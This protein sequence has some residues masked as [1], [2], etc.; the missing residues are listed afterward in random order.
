M[1][2]THY[3][4]QK[5]AFTPAEWLRLTGEARRIVAKAMRAHYSGPETSETAAQA[6]TDEMGFASDFAEKGAWRTFPHPEIAAPAKG[7]PIAICG[8]HG[9]GEPTFSD[10]M[11]ALNGSEAKGQ[12]YESFILEREPTRGEW[13]KDA[14]ETFACCKTEYRPYDPVVVS[15]LAAAVLIAPDAIRATSDGGPGTIRLMF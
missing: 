9:S 14:P 1:G 13:E 10:R 4:H 7:E 2:Y 3:W 15:I 8:S 6:G 11:I 12:D 5:R